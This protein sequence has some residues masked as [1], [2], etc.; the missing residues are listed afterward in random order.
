MQ[1]S[2][3]THGQKCTNALGFRE[4]LESETQE[5]QDPLHVSIL[6][7]SS[8]EYNDRSG[9]SSTKQIYCV[10]G[11][12]QVGTWLFLMQWCGKRGGRGTISRKGA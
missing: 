5:H 10:C 2:C 12:C 4:D 1:L 6:F 9:S 7:H 8:G 11:L 3:E